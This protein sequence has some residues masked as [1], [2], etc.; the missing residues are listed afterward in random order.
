M[1]ATLIALAVGVVILTAMAA[2]VESGLRHRP[3]PQRYA[4]ADVVIAHPT[5]TVTGKDIDGS[6]VRSTVALPEGGRVGADLAE[7]AGRIPGVAAAVADTAVP[8]F[9]PDGPAVARG[10]LDWALALPWTAR[11][12]DTLDLDEHQNTWRSEGWM[13]SGAGAVGAAG[14]TTTAP[15]WPRFWSTAA[16]W[17]SWVKTVRSS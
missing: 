8:V 7:R 11:S 6:T 2:V 10:W 5:V 9:L 4:A 13:G 17:W 15:Y 12:D 1:A 14:S 16:K 3:E